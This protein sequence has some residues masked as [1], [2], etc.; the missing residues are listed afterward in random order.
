MVFVGK[1]LTRFEKICTTFLP[2][3]LSTQARRMVQGL[4]RKHYLAYMKIRFHPNR[5]CIEIITHYQAKC[6]IQ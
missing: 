4:G 6:V 3:S 5:N 2:S 1:F